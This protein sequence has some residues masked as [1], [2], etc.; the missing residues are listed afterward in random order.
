MAS[1]LCFHLCSKSYPTE[2]LQSSYSSLWYHLKT[3]H[4]IE[5]SVSSDASQTPPAKRTKVQ[6]PRFYYS[7]DGRK[8]QS[9]VYAELTSVDHLSFNQQ[10]YPEFNAQE[11]QRRSYFSY[12]HPWKVKEFWEVAKEETVV[13]L[14][15]IKEAGGRFALTFDEWTGGTRD[16]SQ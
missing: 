2:A 5:R 16:T 14:K 11:M 9:M 6:S 15:K 10:F 1:G 12:D 13:E 8:S 4:V 3:K 7:V